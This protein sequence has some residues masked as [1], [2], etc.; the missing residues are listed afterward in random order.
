MIP[1]RIKQMT[2]NDSLKDLVGKKFKELQVQLP[3]TVVR[4]SSI[5]GSGFAMTCD[6]IPT[7]LSVDLV[8]VEVKSTK[9]HKQM[10]GEREYEW[11]EAEYGDKAEGTVAE[12]RW[13]IVFAGIKKWFEG[14]PVIKKKPDHNAM[15]NGLRTGDVVFIRLGS[16][17]CKNMLNQTQ[18]RFDPL[19]L[20]SRLIKGIVVR[21]GFNSEFRCSVVEV[22]SV[23]KTDLGI[24][25]FTYSILADEVETLRIVDETTLSWK[26]S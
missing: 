8:D 4:V 21:A 1:P 9:I 11:S 23:K 7:R 12:C 6:W 15:I 22:Q 2:D 10:I 5:N 18:E 17:F 14:S 16:D 20:S 3:G 25:F 26:T 13:G 24:Q 19:D